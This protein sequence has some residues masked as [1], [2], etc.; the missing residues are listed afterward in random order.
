MEVYT[1]SVDNMAALDC[2]MVV[3][4][5]N[6]KMTVSKERKCHFAAYSVI[7]LY[8]ACQMWGNVC[9]LVQV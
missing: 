1:C 6:S 5:C 4:R 3:I 8:V 7:F 2:T 9:S